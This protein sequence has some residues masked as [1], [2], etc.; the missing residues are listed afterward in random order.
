M[1]NITSNMDSV[2]II[3][4][5][6]AGFQVA[7]SLRQTS[8][9]G[10]ITLIGDEAYM[11]YQRPPLSKA[12]LQ[13]GHDEESLLLRPAD[14][15]IQNNIEIMTG[16][17]VEAVNRSEKYVQF[18]S[19]KLNYTHLV[20]AT[21][22]RV[23]KL[24]I[25]GAELDGVVY[26]RSLDDAKNIKVRMETA[27]NI[28]VIGGGFI[29]L[30]FAAVAR[31]FGKNVT[32][33]EAQSRLMARAVA[34]LVSEY[35]REQHE[36]HGANLIFNVQVKSIIGENNTVKYVE[37]AD[38]YQISAD[39]VVVGIGVISN[40]ELAR[41][42]GLACNN[43]IETDESLCT[44]DP[45]IYAIGDCACNYNVFANAKI[46]VESVQ[47]AVDQAKHVASH[48][49][50]NQVSYKSVPWFWSDQYDLKLQMVGISI[51]FDK[52]VLR[53]SI[54]NNKFSVFY[55]KQDMLISIDTVNRGADHMLGRRLIGQGL[56]V[57][58]EIAADETVDLKIYLS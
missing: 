1:K 21:G 49:M 25:A 12:Y 41:D 17:R 56:S 8:Y 5:G 14:F 55:Y 9:G 38:G 6:Q 28:V 22:T 7:H 29:G 48:I 50:G 39:I 13:G 30:E 32:I 53:G 3:G 36:S 10:K 45:A 16:Q 34:P 26:I 44:S 37:L 31:K 42:A 27:H 54:E 40:D 2:V 20:L 23:R 15:Y 43:G 58:P 11:P 52:A 47:N 19:N 4:A 24:S 46:R 57:P 51:G 35:F 33:I 18:N